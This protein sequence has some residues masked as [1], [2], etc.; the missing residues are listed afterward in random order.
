[1]PSGVPTGNLRAPRANAFV[2]VFQSFID[3]LA[4]AAGKDPLRFSLDLLGAPRMVTNVDGKDGYDVAR[5]RAV[6]ELVG[7]KSGWATARPQSKGT[8]GTGSTGLGLAYHFSGGGYFA[9]V[10]EISVDASRKVK[11]NRVWVGADVGEEIVNP[12]GAV[13]Q[14]QG[15]IIDGLSQLMSCEIT[16]DRGRAVQSNYHEFPPVRFAQAPLQIEVF[17]LK[18]SHPPTGLGEPPLPP[19][20]PAV[21]NA[22]F[23]ASGER[24]RSLPLS[25]HGFS[26]A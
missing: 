7:E 22:I 19:I 23:A 18:T 16:I 25:R 24:I 20:L 8:G 2:F 13:N 15:A 11:I 10:A 1:M 9:E 21:C 4:H 3:E 17:F 6:L 12:S 14:V 26:W 5:M